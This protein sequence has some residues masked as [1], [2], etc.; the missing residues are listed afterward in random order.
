M[1]VSSVSVALLSC[2]ATV[3]AQG[4][5]KG[6]NIGANNPDGSCKTEADWRTAFEKLKALPGS[7]T[8]VR[9]YA[10]SDCNT[11]AAS[12]PAAKAVGTRILVGVWTQDEAH[13][14]AEKNALSAA[15]RT[16]G[17]DWIHSISVGSEDLYRK[18]TSAGRL[19]QQINEVRNIVRGLG[20]GVPVGHVDT[21]TAW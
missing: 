21:W 15:I 8:T 19:A 6:F 4:L 18:E 17:S 13:Y 11:L 5:A 2:V 16:H 12:V 1:R 14:T 20:V 10:T 3:A 9:Q 7:F